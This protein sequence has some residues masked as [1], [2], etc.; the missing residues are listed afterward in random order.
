MYRVETSRLD[1]I[2]IEG[3]PI[4]YVLMNANWPILLSMRMILGKG[5]VAMVCRHHGEI[6]NVHRLYPHPP[7]KP[8]NNLSSVWVDS[9]SHSIQ[10]QRTLKTVVADKCNTTLTLNTFES[11]FVDLTAWIFAA[12]EDLYG[13][14]IRC[15]NLRH[16]L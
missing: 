16:S 11:G 2:R 6:H 13:C 5:L 3:E 7:K 10:R 12:R 8:M 14:L 15:T 9:L 1:Y 4:D